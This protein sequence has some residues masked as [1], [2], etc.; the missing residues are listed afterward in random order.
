MLPFRPDFF[1]FCSMIGKGITAAVFAAIPAAFVFAIC[2]LV[3]DGV[4]GSNHKGDQFPLIGLI[5]FCALIAILTGWA[6]AGNVT[7]TAAPG[8]H[9]VPE[10][11]YVI[12]G[13]GS[14]VYFGADT[15][16]IAALETELPK[17][18]PVI[19][20]ALLPVNGLRVAGEQVVMNDQEAARLAGVLRA[21]VA[22]PIHYMF[23]GGIV[24]DTFVL[25]YHGSADGFVKAAAAEAPAT[26]VRVLAPGQR[27]KIGHVAAASPAQ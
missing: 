22:V 5:W 9:G 3:Y 16:L 7:I 1:E 11:T 18:F 13:G 2:I 10:V 8:A 19:D 24:A 4:T 25:S 23:R 27:L 26:E 20:V 14:T 12:Q 17:R 21:A 6:K 15:K